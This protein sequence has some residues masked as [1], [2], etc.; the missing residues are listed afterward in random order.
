MR[1]EPPT[2]VGVSDVIIPL[3]SVRT[4]LLSA[5]GLRRP[6]LYSGLAMTTLDFFNFF[7]NHIKIIK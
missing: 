1:S 2:Q 3:L 5:T 4:S 7:T 6:S